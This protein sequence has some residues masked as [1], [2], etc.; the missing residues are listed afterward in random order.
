MFIKGS[1]PF[2]G[3]TGSNNNAQI[4]RK[5]CHW[6]LPPEGWQKANFDGVAKGNLGAAGCGGVIRNS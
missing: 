5:E 2:I 1:N 3:E 4:R 6:S